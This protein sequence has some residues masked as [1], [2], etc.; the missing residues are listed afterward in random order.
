MG[1]LYISGR[2]YAFPFRYSVYRAELCTR[3]THIRML[4]A[5]FG[6]YFD[7]AKRPPRVLYERHAITAPA[8]LSV[9]AQ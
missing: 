8:Q 9:F 1:L 3:D 6:M 7:L 4:Q 5:T 2:A